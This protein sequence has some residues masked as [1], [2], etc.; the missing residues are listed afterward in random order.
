MMVYLHDIMIP[1]TIIRKPN[2]NIY[3]RFDDSLCLCI[4][5]NKW[6]SQREIEK[7]IKEKEDALYGMY[8][9]SLKKKE[10]DTSFRYL[11]DHY[12]VVFDPS[13]QNTEIK[14]GF[15]Y[16]KDEKSLAKFWISECF[17]IFS[18]RMDACLLLFDDIP[19]FTLKVRKMKT[20]WGVNN[21]GSKTITLNSELLKEETSLIDYVIIHELCHFKEPNHSNRFWRE[22]EKRYPYY[23][24]ARKKL[25]SE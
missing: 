11:G 18:M 6:V 17:R 2:K 19:S 12:T 7:I 4:T 24:L 16:T 5:C 20:R 13:Y 3:F 9:K 25:R 10:N 8:Q 1:V 21:Y 23:K 15:L 22:V 14:D